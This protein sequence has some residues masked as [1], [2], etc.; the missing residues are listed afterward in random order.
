MGWTNDQQT[1]I[2][3]PAGTPFL[4]GNDVIGLGTELPP[5]L[6]AYIPFVGGTAIQAAII[7][8][9]SAFDP[10]ST[11]PLVKFHFMGMAGTANPTG[12]AL[13]IGLGVCNNPSVS[14]VA[15]CLP[16]FLVG[17]GTQY[18]GHMNMVYEF[19]NHNGGTLGLVGESDTNGSGVFVA[20]D[21]SGNNIGHL[22]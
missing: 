14:T 12:S 6:A 9:N 22:P 1:E 3:A 11:L 4:P 20:F 8:Y 5:E 10:T 21:G 7:F 15:K 2:T 13:L 18:T 16:G 17:A 19:G